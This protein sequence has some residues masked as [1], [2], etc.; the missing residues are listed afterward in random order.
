MVVVQDREG[1]VITDEYVKSHHYFNP[2]TRKA[3]DLYSYYFPEGI[4][5]TDINKPLTYS[6]VNPNWPEQYA[7]RQIGPFR[8]LYAVKDEA[9]LDRLDARK[10]A[11]TS[12]AVRKTAGINF[13][14]NRVIILPPDLESY[15]KLHAQKKD[16]L[17]YWYPSGFQTKDM[18]VMWPPSVPRYEGDAG[19]EY[20]WENEFYEIV[21]HELTHL[22][23]GE[24]TGVFSPVPVWLNEGLAVYVESRYAAEVK[25][26]WDTVYDVCAGGRKLLSWEDAARYST[27]SFPSDKARTHYAQSYKMVEYLISAYGNAKLLRYIVSFKLPAENTDPVDIGTS[28]TDNFLKI[29]GITWEENLAGFEKTYREQAGTKK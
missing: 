1:V 24:V 14:D 29:Y 18:I 4:R 16:E 7:E 17:L 25:I 23:V 20:F 28:F 11:E 26:Y 5:I 10:L 8:I 13:K 21:T 2:Q 27:S 3:E 15:R 6:Y 19:A 12:T 9:W 22:A